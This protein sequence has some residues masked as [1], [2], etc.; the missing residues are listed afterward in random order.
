[1]AFQVHRKFFDSREQLVD[2]F[3]RMHSPD[4]LPSH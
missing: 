4:D 1:M 2:D 3:L